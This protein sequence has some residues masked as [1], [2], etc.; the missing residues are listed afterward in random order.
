MKKCLKN[1]AGFTLI[2]M[3]IV[4]IILGILAMVIIPQISVST[5]DAKVSTLKGSLS[6]LRSA[7]EVY[8]AQHSNKYPGMTKSTDGTTNNDIGVA[9]SSMRLQLTQ[10]SNSSGKVA[11]VKD[12]TFKYG[13]YV[14]GVSLPSN[15]FNEKTQVVCDATTSIAAA[16][17]PDSG[18]GWK[19]HFN[20]GVLY[21]ADSTV[22]AAY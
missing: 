22:H 12:G 19:Y 3:L 9:A 15:P 11:T 13:P 6:G 20:T 17:A 7:L 18:Y 4:I 16:R 14:K 1:Q 21:A 2:E 8:Y 5:E 10:Y